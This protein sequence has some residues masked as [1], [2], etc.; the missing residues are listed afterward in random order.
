MTAGTTPAMVV[1]GVSYVVTEVD[2]HAPGALADFVGA[3]TFLAQGPTGRHDVSG[4][5]AEVDGAVRFHE[6]ASDGAGKDIRV[7]TVAPSS[8]GGFVAIAA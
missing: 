2:G 4:A 1:S 7:W 8:E 6:K 3:V 5:G